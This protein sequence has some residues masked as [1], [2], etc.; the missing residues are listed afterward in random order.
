MQYSTL[1]VDVSLEKVLLDNLYKLCQNAREE[2]LICSVNNINV[3]SCNA[4]YAPLVEHL[5][6]LTVLMPYPWI[7]INTQMF[8]EDRSGIAGSF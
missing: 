5:R 8:D 1:S 4:E 6:N 2:N 7:L 3:V